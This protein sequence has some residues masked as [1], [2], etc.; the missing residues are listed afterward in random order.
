MSKTQGYI[1]QT[2]TFGLSV[3]D[4]SVRP[5][6]AAAPRMLDFICGRACG[7][8]NVDEKGNHACVHHWDDSAREH[9][10]AVARA[11]LRDV[12]GDHE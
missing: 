5:L 8:Q 9:E 12:E 1:D 6:Y 11:I 2:V 3:M 4:E 10:C 7:S